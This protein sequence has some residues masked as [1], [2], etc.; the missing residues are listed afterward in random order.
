MKNVYILGGF[1]IHETA[2]NDYSLLK[3]GLTAK[4]YNVIAVDISWKQ[5]TPS[6]YCH[7][8]ISEFNNS[9]SDYNIVIG[10]S[11]GAVVALM[12]AGI[13]CPDELYLCSL[14]PFFK[15]DRHNYDDSYGIK[16][17]GKRRM[18]DLWSISAN[19]LANDI[20]KLSTKTTV[21]YGQYE[22]VTSPALV[23][24]CTK[25]AKAIKGSNLIEIPDAPHD[26]NDEKYMVYLL[27]LV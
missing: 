8:F 23:E 12:S 24:R 1:D 13:T 25:T 11:F 14:S 16:Y 22:L 21:L 18:V 20:D 4:G 5:T 3:D 10:N 6:Q 2:L 26:M 27:N 7:Q 17:F 9:K 19:K 15:E